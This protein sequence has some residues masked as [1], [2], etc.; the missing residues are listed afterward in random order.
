MGKAK[1]NSFKD[2]K[3]Q[4]ELL[5]KFEYDD[6]R[7]LQYTH[8]P[9]RLQLFSIL[10]EQIVETKGWKKMQGMTDKISAGYAESLKG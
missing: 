6:Q 1:Q 3:M 4:S 2:K 9:G 7:W 5:K 8:S 10:Q